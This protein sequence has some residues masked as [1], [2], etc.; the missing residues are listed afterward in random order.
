MNG[1][2]QEPLLSTEEADALLAAMRGAAAGAPDVQGAELGSPDR[3]LRR[4]LVAADRASEEV[5]LQLRRLMLRMARCTATGAPE[6]P[7]IVP[8]GV[9]QRTLAPGSFVAGLDADGGGQALLVIGPAL[10]AFVLER[11]LGAPLPGAG[12]ETAT[13]DD[14]PGAPPS[15]GELSSFD[16]R[17][18]QPFAAAL[19]AAFARSWCG[20]DEGLRLGVVLARSTDPVPM[21]SGEAALRLALRVSAPSGLSDTVTLAFTAAAIRATTGHDVEVTTPAKP[22]A[23]DRQRMVQRIANAEV[24][25]VATLGRAKSSVREILALGVGDV[26]RLDRAPVDP[27]DVTVEGVTKLIGAPVV[28]HGNLAIEVHEVR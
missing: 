6:S 11:R 28:Q 3:V 22:T 1:E 20:R 18:L 24:E 15:R 16:R 12:A 9:M 13:P 27:V 21:P 7:E 8:V 25:V 2:G 10:A 14:A 5:A 26:L 19:V 23:V 4:A 17:L